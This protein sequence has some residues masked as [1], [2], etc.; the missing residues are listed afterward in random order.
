M[1]FLS[2]CIAAPILYCSLLIRDAQEVLEIT[3]SVNGV[4]IMFLF[5]CILI[6]Y[7]RKNYP[8]INS[9]IYKSTL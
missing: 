9:E 5:P 4:C 6:Y 1:G 3:G 8:D 7:A 2:M